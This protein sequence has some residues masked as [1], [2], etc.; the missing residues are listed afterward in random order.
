MERV[1][2]MRVPTYIDRFFEANL[3]SVI[4]EEIYKTNLANIKL[5]LEKSKDPFRC[6]DRVWVTITENV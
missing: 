6:P 5:C 3:I 1:K 2:V 4:K